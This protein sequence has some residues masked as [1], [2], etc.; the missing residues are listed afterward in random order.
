[1]KNN[2]LQLIKPRPD[3]DI[4]SDYDPEN[5]PISDGEKENTTIEIT[6][7]IVVEQAPP[8]EEQPEMTIDEMIDS[9]PENFPEA[10]P[11][12]KSDIAPM[13]ATCDT[14]LSE[15]Y[16]NLIK[17]K[18]KAGSKKAITD[19]IK[20]YQKEL[21]QETSQTADNSDTGNIQ[22]TD[23][24]VME[25]A[26]QIAVDP[27]SFAKRIDIVQLLGVIG[28]RL[29]SATYLTTMDSRLLPMGIAGSEALAMKNAGHY[30]AGKSFPLFLFLKMFPKS[31]YEIF[32]TGTEKNIIYYEKD[33]LKHKVLIITEA[34][35]L[36]A[37]QKDNPFILAVRSLISEGQII[38]SYTDPSRKTIKITIDG[39]TGLITTT[40]YGKLEPQLESRLITVHPDMTPVQTGNIIYRNAEI[41]EGE[42]THYDDR[43]IR[44]WKH[45]HSSLETCDVIIPYAKRMATMIIVDKST[46]IS[47]RR[48]FKRVLSVI[49]SIGLFHQHQRSR[50]D[51]GRVIADYIDYAL[52]YQIIHEHFEECLGQGRRLKDAKFKL[53]EK[54][55]PIT[56]RDLARLAKVT[57]AAISQWIPEWLE[58]GSLVWVDEHGS[59]FLNDQSLEKAKRTGK[60]Y[61]KVSDANKLPTPYQL[62]GDP[63]WDVGG[64]FYQMYDLGLESAPASDLGDE[65]TEQVS[66]CEDISGESDPVSES[67]HVEGV[68]VLS[69]KQ[70]KHKTNPHYDAFRNNLKPVDQE[71]YQKEIESL[72][73]ETRSLLESFGG[74]PV[75]IAAG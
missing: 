13:L 65:I 73:D 44:A 31:S 60:V 32:T 5:D 7:D 12:I 38:Y 35:S 34:L 9:L 22:E 68:K 17:K 2:H 20:D 69:D 41:A 18:T 37:D 3:E 52:A 21:V 33:Q 26:Q 1:M 43:I 66:H 42:F 15:H 47:A 16:I 48:A 24:E 71:E 70:A 55:G 58:N 75:T 14:G 25:M 51:Q 72:D 63:R 6:D 36:Q 11:I 54:H 64:E 74:L 23:P 67:G 56:P 30:G 62:T 39:P 57:G 29:V 50:D 61:L 45:F 53:V 10:Y 27:L 19:I 46:P 28:E 40:I 8:P 49:K 59:R 4:I